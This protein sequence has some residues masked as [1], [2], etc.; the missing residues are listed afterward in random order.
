[1]PATYMYFTQ[2]IGLGGNECK[3]V[4]T[5]LVIVEGPQKTDL[6]GVAQWGSEAVF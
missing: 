4:F 2:Q 6:L 5:D 1:M 3:A